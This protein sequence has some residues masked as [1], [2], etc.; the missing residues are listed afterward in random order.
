MAFV[1]WCVDA[2]STD[3]HNRPLRRLVRAAFWIKAMT[4]YMRDEDNIKIAHASLTVWILL[5]TGWLLSLGTDRILRPLGIQ[6]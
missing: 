1:V 3:I 6:P 5:T 2:M 4:D